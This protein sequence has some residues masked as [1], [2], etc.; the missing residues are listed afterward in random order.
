MHIHSRYSA[1]TIM[2]VWSAAKK[3]TEPTRATL[4]DALLESFVRRLAPPASDVALAQPQ[5]DS[6]VL[7][8]QLD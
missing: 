1:N 8:Q 2:T 7:D 6:P 4:D 5:E 3:P